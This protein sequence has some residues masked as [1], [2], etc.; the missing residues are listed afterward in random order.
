M[1]PMKAKSVVIIATCAGCVNTIGHTSF[2]VSL[3]S[4]VKCWPAAR[5]VPC[6]KTDSGCASII[7]SIEI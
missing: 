6:R 7:L 4:I 3:S 5:L 2:T 1:C